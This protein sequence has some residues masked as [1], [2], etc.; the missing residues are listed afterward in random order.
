MN[1]REYLRNQQKLQESVCTAAAANEAPAAP[2][3]LAAA[4]AKPGATAE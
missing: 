4:A 1:S 3:P 2:D